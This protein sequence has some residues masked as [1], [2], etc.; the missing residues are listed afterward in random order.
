M[1]ANSVLPPFGFTMRADSSENFAG[2]GRNELSECHRQLPRLN[3]WTRL[4]G[5]SGFPAFA[6]IGNVVQPGRQP[7][8]LRLHDIAAARILALAEIQRERHLLLVGDVL[9]VED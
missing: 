8:I 1:S 5:G 2:I 6:E 4:S 3:R 7:R 9:A